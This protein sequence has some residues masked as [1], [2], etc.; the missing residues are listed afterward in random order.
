VKNPVTDKEPI[1]GASVTGHTGKLVWR[2]SALTPWWAFCA[3]IIDKQKNMK[4]PLSVLV[5][6]ILFIPSVTFASWWNPFTW[7]MFSKPNNA[8]IN[9]EVTLPVKTADKVIEREASVLDAPVEKEVVQKQ[10]IAPSPLVNN[11]VSKCY[12]QA[13]ETYNSF[14]NNIINAVFYIN[15]AHESWK[16]LVTNVQGNISTVDPTIRR[17]LEQASISL[18]IAQPPYFQT[19]ESI[20]LKSNLTSAMDDLHSAIGLIRLVVYGPI[21]PSTTKDSQTKLIEEANTFYLN[22]VNKMEKYTSQSKAMAQAQVD[23]VTAYCN[24]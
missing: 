20:E 15:L 12:A 2:A 18:F 1:M 3:Y 17:N 9:T 8:R 16:R 14:Q 13:K 10:T 11:Q 7:K 4:K 23:A 6:I 21:G 5:L 19:T 24:M 22:F